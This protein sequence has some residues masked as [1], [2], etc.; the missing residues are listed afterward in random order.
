MKDLYEA[1]KVLGMK[2]ERDR[3]RDNVCL[4]QKRYLKKVL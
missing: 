4:T 3:K 1:K 2:I